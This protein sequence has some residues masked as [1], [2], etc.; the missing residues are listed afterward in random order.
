MPDQYIELEG[1]INKQL[2]VTQPFL[3][4]GQ[5]EQTNFTLLEALHTNKQVNLT[6]YKQVQWITE[7]GFIQFADYLQYA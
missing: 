1:A 4:E 7:T 6:Y 2:E 5:M 3:T